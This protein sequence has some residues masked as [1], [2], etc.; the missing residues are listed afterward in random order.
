[1][2]VTNQME[3]LFIVLDADCF[4]LS[5]QKRALP[6]LFCVDVARVAVADVRQVFG[7]APVG[8]LPKYEVKVIGHDAVRDARYGRYKLSLLAGEKFLPL[9]GGKHEKPGVPDGR[10]DWEIV[11]KD[12]REAIVVALG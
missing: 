4:K 11:S 7:Y 5:L 2:N 3:E 12:F 6:L 10:L 9:F 1:M 8:L